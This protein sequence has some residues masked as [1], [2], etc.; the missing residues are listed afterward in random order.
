MS[1][2]LK[3]ECQSLSTVST[4]NHEILVGKIKEATQNGNCEIIQFGIST[5]TLS[6]T[7]R[8]TTDEAQALAEKLNSLSDS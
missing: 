1:A 6:T 8:L 2:D 7:Y 3:D 5:D 4:D